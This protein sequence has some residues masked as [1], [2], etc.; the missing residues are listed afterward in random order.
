[1][2]LFFPVQDVRKVF[3]KNEILYSLQIDRAVR[4]NACD[5]G[6]VFKHIAHDSLMGVL[7]FLDAL[8]NSACSGLCKS[9]C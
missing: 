3:F 5:I 2:Q 9:R 6:E 7:I 8:A 4:A 1:M